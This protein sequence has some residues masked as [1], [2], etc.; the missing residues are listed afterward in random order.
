MHEA[1]QRLEAVQRFEAA[2]QLAAF[3]TQHGLKA[4]GASN[5]NTADGNITWLASGRG[6][7]EETILVMC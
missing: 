3:L 5:P 1:A 6:T 4:T 2:R 7:A